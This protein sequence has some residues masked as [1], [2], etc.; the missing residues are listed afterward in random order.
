MV[1]EV[2]VGIDTEQA[3]VLRWRRRPGNTP[4]ADARRPDRS[5]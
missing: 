5:L 3:G 2:H 1:H 4:L